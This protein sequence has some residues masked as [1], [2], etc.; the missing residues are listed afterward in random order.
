MPI[1]KQF[2]D[3]ATEDFERYTI[4]I[5]CRSVDYEKPWYDDTDEETYR[6]YTD[7]AKINSADEDY[8]IKADFKLNDGTVLKGFFTPQDTND[9]EDGISYAQ[10]HVFIN[11]DSYRFW[12]GIVRP[13]VQY[14]AK[15]YEGL[16]KK[17][18]DVFPIT[19]KSSKGNI[20]GRITGFGYIQSN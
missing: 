6:P 17:R 18:A 8:L 7:T 12:F 4:W 16:G 15:F 9:N 10:P 3:L 1:L 13:E 14:I 19:Y 11:E 5:S 20:K 2:S